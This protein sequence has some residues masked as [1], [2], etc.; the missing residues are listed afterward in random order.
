MVEGS[1]PVD[2][3]IEV[4]E[5]R[6]TP[7][8]KDDLPTSTPARGSPGNPRG[9]GL[10][11][12]SMPRACSSSATGSSSATSNCCCIRLGSSLADAA[13]PTRVLTH[14]DADIGVATFG[15]AE[16]VP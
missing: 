4:D 3:D 11:S 7:V 8:D 1:E 9:G 16:A 13:I 15:H 14:D 10:V 12:P 6:D 2:E 5:V